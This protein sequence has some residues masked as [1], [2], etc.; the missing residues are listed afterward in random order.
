MTTNK[1]RRPNQGNYFTTFLFFW[2]LVGC[3]FIVYLFIGTSLSDTASFSTALFRLIL[4]TLLILRLGEISV[5]SFCPLCTVVHFCTI[6]M[7]YMAYKLFKRQP[8]LV[9]IDAFEELR[10]IIILM[11]ILFGVAVLRYNLHTAA[12]DPLLNQIFPVSLST[13]ADKKSDGNAKSAVA[14]D[15][16]GVDKEKKAAEEPIEFVDTFDEV[17]KCLTERGWIF[18]GLDNCHHC[19]YQKRIFGSAMKNIKFIECR[20]VRDMRIESIYF[21]NPCSQFISTFV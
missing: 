20:R 1:T 12:P 10:Y 7:T 8:P 4:L 17:A 13:E 3:V 11:F 14:A 18:F 16:D 2:C 21:L 15:G 5:G 19:Q 9:F 6:I